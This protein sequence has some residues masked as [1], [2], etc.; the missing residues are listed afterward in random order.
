[1]GSL[2]SAAFLK[3]LVGLFGVV[4]FFSIASFGLFVVSLRLSACFLEPWG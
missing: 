4:V 1:M 2:F 3:C